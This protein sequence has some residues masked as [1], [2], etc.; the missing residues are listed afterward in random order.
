MGDYVDEESTRYCLPCVK[1]IWSV[2]FSTR[3]H[4]QGSKLHS[5]GTVSTGLWPYCQNTDKAQGSSMVHQGLRC[6][7]GF[8]NLFLHPSF[9][10]FWL[11]VL[12]ANSDLMQQWNLGSRLLG[13]M[14][15]SVFWMKQ[16][17]GLPLLGA[18]LRV[19]CPSYI[20]D[21]SVPNHVPCSFWAWPINL[22]FQLDLRSPLSPWAYLV[23]WTL[24]GLPSPVLL[25]YS[26]SVTVGLPVLVRAQPCQFCYLNSQFS[27]PSAEEPPLLLPNSTLRQPSQIIYFFNTPFFLIFLNKQAVLFTLCSTG[28]ADFSPL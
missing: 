1:G 10:G 3:S 2:P 21:V 6:T 15:L 22:A 17:S 9:P 7:N 14:W 18:G 24:D 23:F 26:R 20:I 5:W 19:S 27:F 25:C 11:P 4:C 12:K 8:C 16:G 13:K 28:F